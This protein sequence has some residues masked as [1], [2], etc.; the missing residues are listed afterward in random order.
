MA[1]VLDGTGSITGLTNGAGIAAAALSGQVPDA[2]APSG[3]VIQVVQAV[4]VD[5]ASTTSTSWS[6]I[7]GLSVSITPTSASNK[8]LVFVNVS[9]SN[10]TGGGMVKLVR[11]STDIAVGTAT[12][13]RT[14]AS[15]GNYFDADL[16]SVRTDGITFLDSP[17][18]TSSTIY[19]LQFRIGTSGTM[20]V[21][22][23]FNDSD[24][25]FTACTVSMITVMEIAA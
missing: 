8:V 6:D 4:K 10:D 9:A 16:N 25:A 13:S 23:S 3:S 12:G 17:S 14:A 18:T 11:N 21:N 22:R 1:I 2:N 19:K 24:Q 7:S 15:L 20:V 5:T